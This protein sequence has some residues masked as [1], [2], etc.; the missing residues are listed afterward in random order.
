MKA[1]EPQRRAFFVISP[2]GSPRGQTRSL[3]GQWTI[4]GLWV[5]QKTGLGV[6]NLADWSLL[7]CRKQ[8]A[9]APLSRRIRI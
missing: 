8:G 3:E 9:F 2:S 1:S 4:E 7:L 5:S 6:A